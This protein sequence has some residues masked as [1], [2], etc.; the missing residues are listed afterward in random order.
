MIN[1]RIIGLNE[2]QKAALETA[3]YPQQWN[4]IYPTLGLAGESGE[5]AEK[6]KKTIRDHNGD[7]DKERCD[8]IA[9]ELG[10][11]LWYISVIA[12]DIGFTLQ[13]IAEMNYVKLQSR[14][15]RGKIHGDGD[16]R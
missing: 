3:D 9:S 16:N 10:D 12:N 2:Y 15:R 6:V 11:C 14:K 13:E 8:A 7:F 5:V 1:E 4:I